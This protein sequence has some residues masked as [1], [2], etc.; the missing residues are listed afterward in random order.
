MSRR[1]PSH[2]SE[3]ILSEKTIEGERAIRAEKT[4][5]RERAKAKE[6]T[7]KLERYFTGFGE[8]RTLFYTR[9][10][11]SSRRFSSCSANSPKDISM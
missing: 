2:K 6:K 8:S 3:P 9:S 7:K 11:L 1:K 5:A 4:R 10:Y